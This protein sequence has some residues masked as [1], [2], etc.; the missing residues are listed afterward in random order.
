[1]SSI[2]WLK[3]PRGNLIL[4]NESIRISYNRTAGDTND[5]LVSMIQRIGGANGDESNPQEETAFY[6]IKKDIWRILKGDFRDEYEVAFP[7]Y[8]KCLA[9]YEKHIDQR[10]GWSTDI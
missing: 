5:L 2:V 1:M 6:D 10:S 7:D 9:V 4:E 3:M 8:N